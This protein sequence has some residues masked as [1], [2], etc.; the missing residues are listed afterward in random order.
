MP[1]RSLLILPGVVLLALGILLWFGHVPL[2]MP[3]AAL[4]HVGQAAPYLRA[5]VLVTDLGGAGIMI[6]FA[7]ACVLLLLL[8][9]QGG[10]AAWLFLTIGAGRILVEV[11]KHVIGRTRPDAAGHLVH[12]SSASFPSSHSA[13]SMLTVVALLVLLRP[14]RPISVLCMVWPLL[15]GL[16]RM[17]LGVH[18]PSD[19]LAGWGFGLLWVGLASRW[20]PPGKARPLG[21]A[22]A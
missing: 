22:S 8:R 10:A 20:L 14:A 15:V 12:V 7:V 17:M 4:A 5:I 13:G 2:E 3:L 21:G 1:S 18:W 19:V 16:S 9:R 6:P 11:L